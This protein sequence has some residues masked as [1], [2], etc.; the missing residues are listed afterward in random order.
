MKDEFYGA[1]ILGA[2]ARGVFAVM[3]NDY[4]T[5][6]EAAHLAEV[7]SDTIYFYRDEVL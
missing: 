3:A 1:P 5:E 4:A 6:E 2:D 7:F